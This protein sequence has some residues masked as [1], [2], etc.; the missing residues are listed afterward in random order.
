MP[1]YT[2]KLNLPAPLVRAVT[3]DPY[4]RGHSDYTVTELI[5]P[6]RIV[7]LKQKH[8]DELTEDAADR[9]YSLIGQVAHGI[10]ERSATKELSEHRLYAE[11]LGKLVGGQLDL[12]DGGI[13]MDFKVTSVWAFH[14]GV[15]PEW[16]S[17]INCLAA[18]AARNNIAVTSAQIIALY[19]D[20]S[21]SEARRNGDY[22]AEQV[23]IFP[24]PLWTA[25]RQ[26]NYICARITAHE[27]TKTTLP[28]CTP[29]ERW[30]KP[31]KWAVM[32]EGNKR[33]VKLYDSQ[34]AAEMAA[35]HPKLYVEHRPGVQ[36]RCLDYCP[37]SQFC[38]WWQE[39]PE[40]PKR[41]RPR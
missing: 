34:T 27:T 9:L 30:A 39:L 1:S 4:N 12:L 7:A 16:V 37:V 21:V 22:P 17:Q 18:L 19:R 25:E 31:E 13:L 29:L 11:W 6:A 15:K 36:T 33:A 41:G 8:A 38:S 10:I 14:G 24:V 5:S 28:E 35:V 20:W 32:K 3:N 26:N 2:N 40:N 23:Q